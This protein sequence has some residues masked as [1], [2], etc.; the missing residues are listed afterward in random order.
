MSAYYEHIPLAI[1]PRTMALLEP[2]IRAAAEAEWEDDAVA[3]EL[4]NLA[5]DFA[6]RIQRIEKGDLQT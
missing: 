4:M 5:N 3:S 6:S 1:R 2:I